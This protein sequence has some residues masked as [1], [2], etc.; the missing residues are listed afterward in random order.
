[1]VLNVSF[2][3]FQ[4]SG[5]ANRY[6]W[7]PV[8]QSE[9]RRYSWSAATSHF[10]C[11]AW[12]V[13]SAGKHPILSTTTGTSRNVTFQACSCHP[14]PPSSPTVK[15]TLTLVELKCQCTHLSFEFLSLEKSFRID[16][17]Q[18]AKTRKWR[19]LVV[20]L[21]NCIQESIHAVTLLEI[22]YKH[23]I[24]IWENIP[25]LTTVTFK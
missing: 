19:H 13:P 7:F 25:A 16:D 1:M 10:L 20:V 23:W 24:K 3:A 6:I 5:C 12:Q 22:I 8:L 18:V 9:Q 14:L 2:L 17:F 21:H 11:E 4:K 15:T